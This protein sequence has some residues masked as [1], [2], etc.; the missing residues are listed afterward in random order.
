[1]SNIYTVGTLQKM[2]EW[3]FIPMNIVLS[4]TVGSLIGFIVALLIRPPKDYF[5]FTIVQIGIGNIGNVPFVLIGA[6][7]WEVR[8]YHLGNGL[9]R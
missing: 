1:M 6:I 9:A 7:K 4:S 5:K 8:T 2:L 3:W